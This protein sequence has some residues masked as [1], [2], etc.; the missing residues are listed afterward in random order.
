HRDI[1]RGVAETPGVVMASF[2]S[3]VKMDGNSS[4]DGVEFE[5]SPVEGDALPPI[6][7]IKYI[8]EGYFETMGTP[9]VAGRAIRW[10]DIEA[11]ARVSVISAAIARVYWGDPSSAIGKRLRTFGSADD[12]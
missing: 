11:R 2:S 9:L 1:L 5:E 10:A 6:R 4:N 12:T 8:G 7:R 3:S